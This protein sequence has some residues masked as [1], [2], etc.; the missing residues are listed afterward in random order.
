M[1]AQTAAKPQQC[2]TCA[3]EITG[4]CPHAVA[5]HIPIHR[6]RMIAAGWWHCA[7][8]CATVG[9]LASETARPAV[10]L[11]A[12]RLARNWSQSALARRSGVSRATL[13]GIEHGKRPSLDKLFAL[14]HVF[15][16]ENPLDL[17]EPEAKEKTP[18]G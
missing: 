14:A 8:W 9:H 3:Q 1:A 16:V 12:L 10:G 7:E 2:E 17:L 15:G 13:I 18:G 5:G 11:R 6:R 4:R